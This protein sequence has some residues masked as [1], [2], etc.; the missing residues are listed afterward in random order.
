MQG[1]EDRDMV[2]LSGAHTVGLGGSECQR[3]RCQSLPV[4]RQSGHGRWQVGRFFLGDTSISMLSRDPSF[5]TTISLQGN[6]WFLK[7]T[8]V[9][10]EWTRNIKESTPRLLRVSEKNSDN[11]MLPMVIFFNGR[12]EGWPRK[13]AHG[14]LVG[15]VRSS[16]CG[17]W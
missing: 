4:G 3:L 15:K 9:E 6:S 11:R 10:K 8:M 7:R 16:F 17:D 12:D 1:F 2:A 14:A 13:S 5:Q